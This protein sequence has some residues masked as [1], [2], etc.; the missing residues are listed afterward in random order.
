MVLVTV[1]QKMCKFMQQSPKFSDDE[2]GLTG[3][4]LISSIEFDNTWAITPKKSVWYL[5]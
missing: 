1:D 3:L 4:G 2:T 5:Q